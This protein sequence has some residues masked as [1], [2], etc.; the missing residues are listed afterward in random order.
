MLT[1]AA[2]GKLWE[3]AYDR[4]KDHRTAIERRRETLQFCRAKTIRC[5]TGHIQRGAHFRQHRMLLAKSLG[6]TLPTSSENGILFG[7]EISVSH[8]RRVFNFSERRGRKRELH[9]G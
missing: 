2:I 9:I 3:V 6:P 7:S 4:R 1:A 5:I 8:G